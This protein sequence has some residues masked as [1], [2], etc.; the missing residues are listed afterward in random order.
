EVGVGPALGLDV[1]LGLDAYPAQDDE[2]GEGEHVHDPVPV[3]VD[4]ADTESDRIGVR[5]NEHIKCSSVVPESPAAPATGYRAAMRCRSRPE[6]SG[7]PGHGIL[8][9]DASGCRPIVAQ[10]PSPCPPTPG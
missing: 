7:R 9:P 6:E 5:V 10:V 8:R 3:D 2:Q 4:G 1:G